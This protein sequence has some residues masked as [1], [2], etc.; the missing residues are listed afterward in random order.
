MRKI[1]IQMSQHSTDIEE[2]IFTILKRNEL[3]ALKFD[4]EFI[5]NLARKEWM[6]KLK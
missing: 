4:G 2:K 1:D 5:V 6:T 3:R